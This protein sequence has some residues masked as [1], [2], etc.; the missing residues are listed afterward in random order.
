MGEHCSAVYFNNVF[1]SSRALYSSRRFAHFI[2]S[3][4]L[5]SLLL[6]HIKAISIPANHPGFPGIIPGFIP[7]SRYPGN[8]SLYPG[9]SSIA[10]LAAGV[11]FC[12]SVALIG[13]LPKARVM[14]EA[15]VHTRI[16]H[17]LDCT[18]I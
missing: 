17:V 13:L 3:A 18:Y 10:T 14:R 9:F 6:A 4:Q 8:L 11:V 2:A 1:Y 5:L 16:Y 15:Y 7:L 12:I